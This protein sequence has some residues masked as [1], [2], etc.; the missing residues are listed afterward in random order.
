MPCRHLILVCLLF[1]TQWLLSSYCYHCRT[2]GGMNGGRVSYSLPKPVQ[3]DSWRPAFSFH[4]VSFA[5]SPL[6]IQDL[7]S[8][9]CVVAACTSTTHL[10]PFT[11]AISFQH[12]QSYFSWSHSCRPLPSHR[13][14]QSEPLFGIH[15]HINPQHFLP[16]SPSLHTPQVCLP[17]STFATSR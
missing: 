8:I 16:K 1:P 6:K 4:T 3:S 14:W 13:R 2:T 10:D 9:H 11:A 7:W 17:S 5:T 15:R 12:S